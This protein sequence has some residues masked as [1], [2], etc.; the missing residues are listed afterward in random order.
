[1]LTL[2]EREMFDAAADL[3]HHIKNRPRRDAYSSLEEFAMDIYYFF[4]EKDRILARYL[5]ALNN[6]KRTNSTTSST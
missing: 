5:R 2:E 3:K 6:Y 1:M 4:Q